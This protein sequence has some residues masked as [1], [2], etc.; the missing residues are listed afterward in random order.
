MFLTS[1][2]SNTKLL[3]HSDKRRQDKFVLIIQK[4][5]LG[6]TTDS[7]ISLVDN[8]SQLPTVVV[9]NGQWSV[10]NGESGVGSNE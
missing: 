4:R 2:W 5:L 8:Q 10:V 7:K 1:L 3:Q 6:C 9:V